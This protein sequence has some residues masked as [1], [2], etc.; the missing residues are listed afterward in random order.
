MSEL[1][2]DPALVYLS[3]QK[4]IEKVG[5]QI[6]IRPEGQE[7]TRADLEDSTG[8]A[9]TEKSLILAIRYFKEMKPQYGVEILEQINAIIEDDH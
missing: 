4:I 9:E 5:D 2:L 7:V 8:L 1:K 3:I 6:K